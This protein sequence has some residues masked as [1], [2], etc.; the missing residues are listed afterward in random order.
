MTVSGRGRTLMGFPLK[1]WQICLQ[2]ENCLSSY[3][4]HGFLVIYSSADRSSFLIAERV[5]QALWTS[6]NIAQKAVILVGNKADL[7]RSRCITSEGELSYLTFRLVQQQQNE[8]FPKHNE[9]YII[10]QPFPFSNFK[11]GKQDYG[12][13]LWAMWDM[14]RYWLW[15]SNICSFH[16]TV[17]NWVCSFFCS[18]IRFK[19]DVVTPIWPIYRMLAEAWEKVESRSFIRMLQGSFYGEVMAWWNCFRTVYLHKIYSSWI[20]I[21]LGIQCFVDQ[22]FNCS[23][24]IL[25][26]SL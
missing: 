26:K 6:E 14:L 8:T 12:S 5:L 25:R 9:E 7:A 2:P 20:D 24:L 18:V 23:K 19:T 22:I 17:G 4:P 11:S 1:L 3:D 16:F 13:E 21:E 10:P 15:S